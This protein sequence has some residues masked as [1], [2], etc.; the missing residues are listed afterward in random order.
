MVLCCLP[1]FVCNGI[2]V[3]A[4]QI[5][6]GTEFIV[7]DDNFHIFFEMS[8]CKNPDEFGHV[9]SLAIGDN[10]KIY[11]LDVVA[12]THCNHWHALWRGSFWCG[13][14]RIFSLSLLMEFRC[15]LQARH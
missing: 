2:F 5:C 12:E 14:E 3:Y 10:A 15:L 11:I 13:G 6:C 7:I 9:Y 4:M 8:G 1:A